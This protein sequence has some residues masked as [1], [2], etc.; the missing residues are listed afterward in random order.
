M[1]EYDFMF[2]KEKYWDSKSVL[3]LFVIPLYK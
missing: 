1:A 2:Q 3:R